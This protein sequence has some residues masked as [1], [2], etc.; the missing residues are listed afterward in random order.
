MNALFYSGCN[1]TTES[2]TAHRQLCL[3]IAA[4]LISF[5]ENDSVHLMQFIE[6]ISN[7]AMSSTGTYLLYFVVHL[8]SLNMYDYFVFFVFFVFNLSN[9]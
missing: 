4:S 2:E 7:L 6:A 9:C 3:C 1:Q 5:G 8:T